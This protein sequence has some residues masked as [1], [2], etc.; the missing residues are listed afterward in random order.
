VG[1]RSGG[2]LDLVHEGVTGYLFEPHVASDLRAQLRRL[3]A[4]S[5]LRVAMGQA[6]R[7]VA[8]ER[9]W[10]SVMGELMGYY[11][12]ILRSSPRRQLIRRVA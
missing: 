5:D 8:A 1:A 9:S 10:P 3:L 6:G 12:H 4:N 7:A 2:T 11:R